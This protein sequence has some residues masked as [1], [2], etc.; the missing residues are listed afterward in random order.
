MTLSLSMDMIRNSN[1]YGTVPYR[2]VPYRTILLHYPFAYIKPKE[3]CQRVYI[4][5]ISDQAK[6]NEMKAVG[7]WEF[8]LVKARIGKDC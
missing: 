3:I 8:E 2:S 1:P 5:N 7:G 6:N 4:S